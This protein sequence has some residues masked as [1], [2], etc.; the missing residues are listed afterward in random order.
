MSS[1][2]MRRQL[3]GHGGHAASGDFDVLQTGDS[4]AL[5]APERAGR[6]ADAGLILDR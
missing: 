2:A 5:S 4:L 1:I 3:L 6:D